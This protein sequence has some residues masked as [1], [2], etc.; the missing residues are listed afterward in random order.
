MPPLVL[1]GQ[2]GAVAALAFAR[3]GMHVTSVGVDRSVREWDMKNP[4]AAPML[5]LGPQGDVRSGVVAFSPNGLRLVTAARD[6]VVRFWANLRDAQPVVLK[7][8]QSP[9]TTFAFSNDGMRLA[10][11]ASITKYGSGICAN[12]MSRP[13]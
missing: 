6:N 7:G 5:A 9:V 1:Q 8:Q 4:G 12:P 3:D 11:S 2:Q 13:L 10:S